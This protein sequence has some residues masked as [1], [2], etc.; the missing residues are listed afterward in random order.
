MREN[1]LEIVVHC[2]FGEDDEI[3]PTLCLD[4]TAT[5]ANGATISSG[6]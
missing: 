1:G 5:A 3:P 6:G 4:V 2:V